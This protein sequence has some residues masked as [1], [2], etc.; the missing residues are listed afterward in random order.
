M[1]VEALGP[2]TPSSTILNELSEHSEVC[3]RRSV[4]TV[5]SEVFAAIAVGATAIGAE[6]LGLVTPGG[7][8]SKSIAGEAV[9]GIVE[10]VRVRGKVAIFDRFGRGMIVRIRLG[11]GLR[12]DTAKRKWR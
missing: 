2:G 9:V 7:V 12:R 11:V 5:N 3:G 10:A 4:G 8:G 6:S 1:V